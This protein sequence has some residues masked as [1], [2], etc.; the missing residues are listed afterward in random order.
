MNIV[1]WALLLLCVAFSIT[2]SLTD[3]P[4][5]L[6]LTTWTVKSL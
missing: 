5:P 1:F 4:V 6:K 3:P 2:A